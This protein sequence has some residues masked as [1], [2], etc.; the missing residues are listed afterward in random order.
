MKMIKY[1]LTSLTLIAVLSGCNKNNIEIFEN[2][3]VYG[4]VTDT[5]G[6]PIAGVMVMLMRQHSIILFAN[7]VHASIEKSVQTDVNGFYRLKFHYKESYW[8][9]FYKAPYVYQPWHYNNIFD[10]KKG[11]HLNRN[12]ILED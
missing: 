1:I 2:T 3:E 8:I 9:D 11:D 5:S 10:F 12:I 6:H 7:G 4:V